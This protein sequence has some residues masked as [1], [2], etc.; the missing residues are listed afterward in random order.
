MLRKVRLAGRHGDRKISA[1]RL[2]AECSLVIKET[3]EFTDAEI[4]PDGSLILNLRTAK[5]SNRAI[6]H[7]SRKQKD[8]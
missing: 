3:L 8:D 4:D 1:F 2:L 7:P 6:N 5:I